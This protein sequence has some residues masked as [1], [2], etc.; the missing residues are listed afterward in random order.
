MSSPLNIGSPK[1][2]PDANGNQ[3]TPSGTP[4][5]RVLR[6]QYGGTPPLPNVPPRA[7][8]VAGSPATRNINL[9]PPSDGSPASRRGSFAVGGISRSFGDQSGSGASTPSGHVPELDDLPAEEKAKVLRRHLVSR[10]ERLRGAD[11]EQPSGSATPTPKRSQTSLRSSGQETSSD[12]HREESDA[13]PI[14]YETPGADITPRERAISFTGPSSS[15]AVDPTF[16]HIHEPGGFRR[17]YLKIKASEQGVAHP[18]V[19]NNFIDFLFIF[20]HF[21]GEDLEEEDEL[22]S[23]EEDVEQ[24]FTVPVTSTPSTGLPDVDENTPLMGKPRHSTRSAS[25]RRRTATSTGPHGN[26]TVTQAVMMLLKA[27][28]GTGILF[29]GRGFYNGGLLF[30]A[31]LFVFIAMVSLYTFLLLVHT[32][33]EVSGSFGDIGGK[34]YGNW[35]RYLILGSIVVSQLGF[36][37]AYIIFVAQNL[38]A[39][40]MGVTKCGT[41]LPMAVTIGVQVVVFLPLV[42]IRDLAKLSTTALVADAFILFGLIYIFGTEISIVAERGAA[43]VQAF[44]YNSFSLFVGT[45]VFSFEGIGLVIPITDAMKEPRKFPKA[46]TGVMFFLTVLFGGA[47]ALGYLTFGSEIQTNVLVNFDTSS[48]IV[49][50]VQFLYA[51]AILLSVP[52]QIF[53]ATRILENGL[54]VRSGKQDNYVKWQKNCLRFVVVFTCAVISWLG[55]DDLDKFVAFIGCF[56]CVPLCYV[57]PAMLHLKAVARTRRQKVADI[58]MMVFGIIACVFTTS[59]TLKLMF[60]P[61]PEGPPIY[62]C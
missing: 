17:N 33:Y 15:T 56:A 42:L 47:G 53:P 12:H 35:M 18:T 38:Q 26:A 14:S 5:I 9:M 46:I 2:A 37:S 16:E 27:F 6:A 54:F 51:M 50:T 25:R 55:A 34:L 62:K 36:V 31:G 30:S 3:Q 11:S 52:L 60:E 32:K 22:K 19:V 1:R 59:Q 24:Q 13:F 29:L 48:K 58:A 45:A 44:N 61:A 40:V 20:G 21:A 23:E 57:Y 39:F 7:G 49:Q 4:D 41:Y 43:Q 10:E 8:S 28:I